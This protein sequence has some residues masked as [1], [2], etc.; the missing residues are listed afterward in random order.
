MLN[1]KDMTKLISDSLDRK[2][3]ITQRLEL[4]AHIMMC[5]VCRR[6]RANAIALR[7]KIRQA[8]AECEGTGLVSESLEVATPLPHDAKQRLA[9]VIQ[10]E[11]R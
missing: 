8:K 11:L 3:S 6:F 4:W 9:S 7:N 5:G 2:I 10:E 1:C